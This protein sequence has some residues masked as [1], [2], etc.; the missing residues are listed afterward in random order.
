MQ[1]TLA[2]YEEK[3]QVQQRKGD[4]EEPTSGFAKSDKS[5]LYVLRKFT[6]SDHAGDITRNQRTDSR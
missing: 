4:D 1:E 3:T 2:E 6:V 5:I